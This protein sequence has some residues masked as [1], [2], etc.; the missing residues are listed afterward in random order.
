LASTDIFEHFDEL[1]DPRMDR[2][3]RH[4]LTNIIFIAVCAVICGGTSFVDMYDFGCAKREWLEEQLELPNG[5]PSHDTFRRVFSLINPNVFRS[6]FIS[7]TQ[8]LSEATGGDIIAFDGKTL[9]RSFDTATGLSAIHV[10]NAWSCENDLCLGQM[11]VDSKSN[12]ITAMPA[13]MKLMEIK[14]SVVTAD[15]LNCQKD[16]AGQ[17]IDGGGDYVLAVKSNQ[18]SLYEDVKL[19]FEDALQEGF[20]VPVRHCE[21]DDW[22][23]G[24]SE[25]RRCWVVSVD[26][27]EWF[28]HATDW[29]GLKSIACVQGIRRT[30][31]AESTES[32]YFISS[33]ES[34]KTIAKAVRHHWSIENKC[35]WVMDVDFAEDACRVRMDHAPENFALLRQMAHNLIKGESSKGFSIRRKMRKAAYDTGFLT[36]ILI[37]V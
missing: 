34:E 32:R 18:L 24:R 26:S 21:S 13:L 31:D 16:I 23:H 30:R 19:F 37:G 22:G 15:A 27:L 11:K 29:K 8:A 14:G 33:L 9:R 6:C 2:Q 4:L 12:E 28:R 7:W 17:V 36:R 1:E 3:K 35:H 25:T 10:V 5:I 20:D